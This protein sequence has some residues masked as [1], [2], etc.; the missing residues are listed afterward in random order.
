[1]EINAK[2]EMGEKKKNA[3]ILINN[4]IYFKNTLQI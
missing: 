1:M 2:G 3:S 4:E